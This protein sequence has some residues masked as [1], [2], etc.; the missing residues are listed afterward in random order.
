MMIVRMMLGIRVRG[1]RARDGIV[2]CYELN[3][4]LQVVCAVGSRSVK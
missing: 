3:M 2:L 1:G 4:L